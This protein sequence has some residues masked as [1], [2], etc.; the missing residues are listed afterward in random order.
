MHPPGQQ[1]QRR[2][3][4]KGLEKWSFFDHTP[5]SQA[6]TALNQEGPSGPTV[7]PVRKGK[8]KIGLWQPSIAGGLLGGL[9]LGL[10]SWGSLRQL[11]S[12]QPLGIR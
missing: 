12:A 1:R 4:L 5:V 9:Y 3:I 11:Y 8:L 2:A 6:G 10:A 7:S